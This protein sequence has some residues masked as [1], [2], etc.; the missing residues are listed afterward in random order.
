MRLF[1]GTEFERLPSCERC[2]Q[3]E[4]DCVCPPS[5]AE[6]AAPASQTARIRIERRK[7]GKVVTTIGG[8]DPT[9]D[10]LTGLLTSLKN[11]CGA[12]GTLENGIVEIQGD[13]GQRISDWLTRQGYRVRRLG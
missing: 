5:V 7:K 4:T 13:H 1:S 2:E 3:L 10:H 9:G 8:L 6:A 11:H 12:G